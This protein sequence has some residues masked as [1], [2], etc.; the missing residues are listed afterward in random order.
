MHQLS[1]DLNLIFWGILIILIDLS[2]WR[3]VNGSGIKIDLVNDLIGA[4]VIYSAVA[5]I[6]KI[7]IQ[8]DNY[9]KKMLFAVL[10]AGIQ[11]F[12]ALADFVIMEV[13]HLFNVIGSFLSLGVIWGGIKFCE[14][15]S[16]L[17]IEKS[18]MQSEQR[19]I[20]VKKLVLWIYFIPS[21][22]GTLLNLLLS[23]YKGKKYEWHIDMGLSEG[24]GFVILVILIIAPMIYA[25]FTIQ[26]MLREI[27]TTDSEEM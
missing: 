12:F 1:R 14:S 15:M 20:K 25:L 22:I 21:I 26:L 2:F 18:L 3:T 5:R 11:F 4:I 24:I 19:W 16:L 27:R 23:F 17:S 6:G 10:A 8:N 9:I 13:P 7:E